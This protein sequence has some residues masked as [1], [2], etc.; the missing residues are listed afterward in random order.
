MT[1]TLIF[2]ADNS[3]QEISFEGVLTIGRDRKNDMILPDPLVSRN[4]ALIRQLGND[5]YY[6]IDSGSSNGSYL[7]GRRITTPV[8]LQDGDTIAIGSTMI[9]FHQAV[10]TPREFTQTAAEETTILVPNLDIE[11]I[12]ILVADIRGF[13]S[14]SEAIPIKTL[15][16]IMSEWFRE[17]TEC[18]QRSG[19][20]VDKFI[21]DC[22]YAR[23]HSARSSCEQDMV[24]NSLRAAL[25]INGVTDSLYRQNPELPH[26]LHIGV[27]INTGQAAVG[28]GRDNTAIGD[29][30]NLAFRL[31]TAS[32]ELGRDIVISASSYRH[33]PEELWR[34]RRSRVTVKGKKEPVEVCG[35]NFDELRAALPGQAG[36]SRP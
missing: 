2:S 28:V 11:D 27:G 23:W 12:T 4:H 29:A 25:A 33:L 15:T 8:V 24:W 26:P 16:R 17:V 5:D 21:G 34:D 20:I 7:N 32:K 9:R 1:A 30:V 10:A 13:T 3:E 19:G 35:L 31:E 22:V 18:V 6:L 36:Q 14:L